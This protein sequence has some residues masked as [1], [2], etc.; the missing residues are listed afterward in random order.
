LNIRDYRLITN[1]CRFAR[2]FPIEERIEADVGPIQVVVY[3]L[4]AQVGNR[5]GG[6]TIW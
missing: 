4:G 6:Q 2:Y 1:S 5:P 3:N